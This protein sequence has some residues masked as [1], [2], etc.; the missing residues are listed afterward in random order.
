MS[1]RREPAISNSTWILVADRAQAAIYHALWPELKHLEAIHQ[2]Q[3][4]DGA[5]EQNGL[6]TDRFGR[7]ADPRAISR[8]GEPQTDYRH[9]TAQE[10]AVRLMS[11]LEHGRA[12]SQFGRL[13]V[14]AP[15]LML[16]IL[17]DKY[18]SPL[19]KCV[20]AEIDKEL[21]DLP[22]PELCAHLQGALSMVTGS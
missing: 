10:F 5:E 13:I 12:T 22:V 15:P 14:V 9:R 17:R 2:I 20:V 11:E 18:S 7:P 6:T 4:T 1:Y 21:V 8:L 16:G 3:H 19:Q